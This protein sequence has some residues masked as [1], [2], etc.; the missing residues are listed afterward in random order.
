MEEYKK[1]SGEGLSR[2]EFIRCTAVLGEASW[3]T[4]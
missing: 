4:A 3:L 1:E 2:R